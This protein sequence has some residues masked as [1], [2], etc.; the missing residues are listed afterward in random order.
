[1]QKT[2]TCE[3]EFSEILIFEIF[4]FKNSLFIEHIKS[5]KIRTL[6]A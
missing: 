2:S 3:R 1:M 4:T 5:K 6:D